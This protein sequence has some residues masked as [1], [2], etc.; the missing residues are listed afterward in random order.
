M[1]PS[2]PPLP[3][4]CAAL[5]CKPILYS[6]R[7]CQKF[8]GNSN[9]IRITRS[10]WHDVMNT[11]TNRP[12]C[13]YRLWELIVA[14]NASSRYRIYANGDI[15]ARKHH[16]TMIPRVTNAPEPSRYGCC[17]IPSVFACPSGNNSQDGRDV[18]NASS[19]SD[20]FKNFHVIGYILR[21]PEVYATNT[22]HLVGSPPSLASSPSTLSSAS[23][24]K[25]SNKMDMP[26]PKPK[27]KKRPRHR[28]S[29]QVSNIKPRRMKQPRYRTSPLPP[30]P[31]TVS[32]PEIVETSP[33][34]SVKNKKEGSLFLGA[35]TKLLGMC[36]C[37][38]NEY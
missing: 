4:H 20:K 18:Q 14:Y 8:D 34:Q 32:A 29:P 13:Y 1:N 17:N 9:G 16:P 31:A 23:T 28:A 24:I 22:I 26:Q 15:H 11:W 36:L 19:S 33:Y 27:R 7:P 38:Q 6:N 5:T 30:T 10:E 21:K 25:A 2:T 35:F 37:Y 3:S 12:F